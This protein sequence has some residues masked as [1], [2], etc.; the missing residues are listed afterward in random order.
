[1]VV[2]VAA[3]DRM[4]ESDRIAERLDVD[5]LLPQVGQGA[6]AVEC[7][8]GDR[9]LVGLVGAIDDAVVR[10]AVETERAYLA[11]LGGDCDLP[12]GAYATVEGESI[13]VRVLL[14]SL[15]ARVV[16]RH[17]AEGDDPD[18]LGR[19]AARHLLDDAGGSELLEAGP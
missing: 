5:V 7:R 2:A 14:A 3:L 16:L 17:G 11:E 18:A 1:V 19:A 15:D 8:A 9:D 4:G 13:R 10:R 12:A 6:L